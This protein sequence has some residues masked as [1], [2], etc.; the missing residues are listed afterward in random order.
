MIDVVTMIKNL[1]FSIQ[2]QTCYVHIS[3]LSAQLVLFGAIQK[4]N[5]SKVTVFLLYILLD[6]SLGRNILL[7]KTATR[8][9]VLTSRL[10]RHLPPSPRLLSK[11]MK[12]LYHI[13]RWT[14]FSGKYVKLQAKYDESLL[15][16]LRTPTWLEVPADRVFSTDL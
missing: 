6:F 14:I 11:T 1:L 5:K 12:S 4:I 10:F 3:L 7:S 2:S 15:C 16:S 13:W 9:Q 8:L